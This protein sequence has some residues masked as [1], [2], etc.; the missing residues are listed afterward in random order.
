MRRRGITLIEVLLVVGMIA[1]LTGALARSYASAIGF[2]QHFREGRADAEQI[3]LFEDRLRTLLEHAYLSADTADTATYFIGGDTQQGDTS[4]GPPNTITFSAAGQR[5]SSTALAS[6]DDFETMNNTIGP[7][8]GVEEVTLGM[9]PVGQSTS[10][11]SGLFIREQRPA[12]GD[13]TQGGYEKLF[14]GDI[15]EISFEFYDGSQWQTAWDTR[16]GQ[17]RL[18]AAVRIQY[19]LS[20]DDANR[21]F[22]VKLPLSDVTPLNPLTTETQTQ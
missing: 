15:R 14:S 3:R 10:N 22:I 17:K 6:Q 21:T 11:Q 19:K 20:N 18:P 9:T 7:Q 1:I 16:T 8:G 2:E 13:P 5:I 4:G 12:D